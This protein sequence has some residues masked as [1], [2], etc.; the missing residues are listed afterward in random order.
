MDGLPR[1][2]TREG[3]SRHGPAGLVPR[4]TPA[5]PKDKKSRRR[6][7]STDRAQEPEEDQCDR[8][9]MADG[10]EEVLN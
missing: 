7:E 8:K 2:G 6:T 10:G 4:A 9:A 3:R 1:R 5:A